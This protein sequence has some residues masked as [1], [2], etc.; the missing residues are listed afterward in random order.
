MRTR[1][2]R[3]HSPAGPRRR[4]VR[5]AATVLTSLALS[6][7][8]LPVAGAEPAGPALSWRPGG[9]TPSSQPGA[10]CADLLFVGARG[11]GEEPPYG[12]TVERT[13]QALTDAAAGGTGREVVAREV[14]LDFP[15]VDPH[16]L[17]E[18]GLDRLLLDAELP[19]TGYL[20]SVDIGV[21]QLDQVLD[22]SA[23]R[24]PDE[25]WVLAGFSQGAQVLT[26]SL[27]RRTDEWRLAGVV[28]VGDPALH[29][30]QAVVRTST[31]RPEATGLVATLGYVRDAVARGRDSGE[32]PE[33]AAT[34]V[35]SVIEVGV[36]ETDRTRMLAAAAEDD[37]DLPVSPVVV[38]VCRS[39]DLVCDAGPA[40][41]R[42]A[43][44]QSRLEAELERTRP[45]HGGYDAADL[46]PAARTVLAG[47][48]DRLPPPAPP[49]V[50][51]APADPDA[52][53]VVAAGLAVVGVLAAAVW[54][55][56]R[57][58]PRPVPRD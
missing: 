7:A 8:A 22:D 43:L 33:G 40:L 51:P 56:R 25:R 34:M 2:S 3:P 31:A 20:R 4:R 46:R 26:T 1:P 41:L 37:L 5:L 54:R 35:R 23:T 16:T 57:R 45:V 28:L 19:T 36:G 29:P 32:D 9:P 38:S 49:A 12:G 30:G 27:S 58:T 13:R 44:G 48:P 47:L 42:M 39:G 6:A 17:A 18:V 55:W 15:A 11:S 52:R 50:P 24:C 14:W 53:T 10:P 21:Q